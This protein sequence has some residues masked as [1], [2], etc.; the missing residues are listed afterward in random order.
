MSQAITKLQG[1]G[2]AEKPSTKTYNYFD[3]SIE[4]EPLLR[5]MREGIDQ[6]IDKDLGIANRKRKQLVRE[7]ISKAMEALRNENYQAID[8]GFKTTADIHNVDKRFD[9]A[10]IAA[11]YV[12]EKMKEAAEYKKQ[13]EPPT[14]K[15]KY[16]DVN[17]DTFIKKQGYTYD[18]FSNNEAG[19]NN[20]RTLLTDFSKNNFND[21]DFEGSNFTDVNSLQQAIQQAQTA[22]GDNLDYDTES[23]L[24]RRLGLNQDILQGFKPQKQETIISVENPEIDIFKQANQERE[25]QQKSDDELF[26]EFWKTYYNKYYV[27]PELPKGKFTYNEIGT[28]TLMDRMLAYNKYTNPKTWSQEYLQSILD[29]AYNPESGWLYNPDLSNPEF[30]NKINDIVNLLDYYQTLYP[31]TK[32]TS[33]DENGNTYYWNLMTEPEQE[34]QYIWTKDKN[35]NII[36]AKMTKNPLFNE[37]IQDLQEYLKQ[38]ENKEYYDNLRNKVQQGIPA[39][40]KGGVLKA[41]IGSRIPAK[42]ISVQDKPLKGYDAEKEQKTQQAIRE[43]DK[44]NF[45]KQ[46]NLYLIGAAADLAS[47]VVPNTPIVGTGISALLGGIGTHLANQADYLDPKNRNWGKFATNTGY[48]LADAAQLIPGTNSVELAKLSRLKKIAPFILAYAAD[49]GAGA[50]LTAD[51]V[52][53]LQKL[54]NNKEV[55]SEEWTHVATDVLKAISAIMGTT[56]AHRNKALGDYYDK[57]HGT[58]TGNN[59]VSVITDDAKKVA[60][61]ADKI[62]AIRNNLE[63]KGLFTFKKNADINKTAITDFMKETGSRPKTA[64]L[65]NT[66]DLTT[67]EV[68]DSR[69]IA[70]IDDPNTPNFMDWMKKRSNSGKNTDLLI[71]SVSASA[72]TKSNV[73]DMLT[74]DQFKSLDKTVKTKLKTYGISTWDKFNQFQNQAFN[75]GTLIDDFKRIGLHKVGGIIIK[76]QKGTSILWRKNTIIPDNQAYDVNKWDDYYSYDPSQLVINDVTGLNEA[77]NIQNNN[78]NLFTQNSKYND[79]GYLDWNKAFNKSGLNNIFGYSENVA[80]YYGPSTYNR[81]GLL[82]SLINKSK[83]EGGLKVNNGVLTFDNQSNQF[84]F[85]PNSEKNNDLPNNPTSENNTELINHNVDIKDK[86][87]GLFNKVKDFKESINYNPNTSE[88]IRLIGTIHTNTVAANKTEDSLKATMR[89][90]VNLQRQQYGDYDA[91]SQGQLAKAQLHTQAKQNLTSDAELNNRTQLEAE[92]LGLDKETQGNQYYNQIYRDSREKAWQTEA[93]NK[94]NRNEVAWANASAFNAIQKAKSDIQ[95]ARYLANWKSIHDYLAGKEYQFKDRNDRLNDLAYQQELYKYQKNYENDPDYRELY[96]L[97]NGTDFTNSTL[98]KMR[99]LSARLEAKYGEIPFEIKRK[100]IFAAKKGMKVTIKRDKNQSD[101][102]FH[103]ALKDTRDAHLKLMN[104]LSEVTK[105]LIL[106]AMT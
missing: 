5:S 50:A 72:P 65:G 106:K 73:V 35:G 42:E 87:N 4:L 9:P 15:K 88:L 32:Y 68:F 7:E 77:L 45:I 89:D 62:Q 53:V 96:Q 74:E 82:N 3:K 64:M 59:K 55:S 93:A 54:S 27:N 12:N 81:Y 51:A 66:P 103:R 1:G 76:A 10:A 67:G 37:Y 52:D 41:L 18:Q 17:L 63:G 11:Y 43:K 102:T 34:N 24:L 23:Q 104:N 98:D 46:N 97:S 2:A 105:K 22:I 47:I 69:N 85:T 6:Y 100:Y 101:R 79:L 48:Y 58:I 57:Y 70:R 75:E 25:Q 16:S 29:E 26:N 21:I 28:D 30:G 38:K 95:V 91:L 20:L 99:E 49:A 56:R 13:D 78:N 94:Q 39:K 90:P 33:K 84:V 80:D 92:R 36:P 8:T 60:I 71:N 83:V 14:Q 86:Y 61:D 19:L 31:E 44:Q 40:K